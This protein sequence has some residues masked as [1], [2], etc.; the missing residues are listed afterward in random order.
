MIK[1]KLVS[2]DEVAESVFIALASGD[3]KID[4]AVGENFS[5]NGWRRGGVKSLLKA[6]ARRKM[7]SDEGVAESLKD[8]IKAS[9]GTEIDFS[10]TELESFDENEQARVEA[11]EAFELEIESYPE[12]CRKHLEILLG[13][14][15]DYFDLNLIRRNSDGK[16]VGVNVDPVYGEIDKSGEIVVRGFDDLAG[17]LIEC[18]VPWLLVV[19]GN[20][21]VS[22][23]KLAERLVELYGGQM[24]EGPER[25]Y[26]LC[27]MIVEMYANRQKGLVDE[28]VAELLDGK[29][30]YAGEEYDVSG[31][32]RSD[33]NE[34]F[35]Y[36]VANNS[37]PSGAKLVKGDGSVVD[38]AVDSVKGVKTA[39]VELRRSLVGQSGD[40]KKDIDN[41]VAGSDTDA[42][43]LE[44]ISGKK[45]IVD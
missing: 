36:V 44:A 39:V 3:S 31:D 41:I 8:E 1:T 34:M 7:R 9:L 11:D 19:L 27:E 17:D 4:D 10:E 37:V 40:L 26:V 12:V 15:Y 45:F 28:S 5:L 25:N 16:V 38:A 22:K 42:A 43:K 13:R 30:E 18:G 14:R 6:V 2:Y 35:E 32:N 24:I 33:L 23:D 20:S 29:V 21:E